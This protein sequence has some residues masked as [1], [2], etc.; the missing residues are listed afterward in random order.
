MLFS[1]GCFGYLK[2][3][4]KD[5]IFWVIWVGLDGPWSSGAVPICF[6]VLDSCQARVC[7]CCPVLHFSNS[8][9]SSSCFSGCSFLSAFQQPQLQPAGRDKQS[10]QFNKLE[11]IVTSAAAVHFC[12]LLTVAHIGDC[13]I[14]LADCHELSPEY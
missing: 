1:L 13:F 3:E 12:Y 6:D 10:F 7:C 9:R 11:V 5:P 14:C 2:F 8:L 4:L